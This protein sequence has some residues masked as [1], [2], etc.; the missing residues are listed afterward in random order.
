LPLSVPDSTFAVWV[1]LLELPAAAMAV[2][3]Y[4]LPEPG[5]EEI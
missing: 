2:F 5:D 4:F 1:Y 3:G